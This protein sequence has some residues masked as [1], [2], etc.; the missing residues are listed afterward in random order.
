[1]AFKINEVSE[2]HALGN[3]GLYYDD[4]CAISFENGGAIVFPAY[5]QDADCVRV[6]DDE[7]R[8]LG[9][10]VRDEFEQ[11]FPSTMNGFLGSAVAV[12]RYPK[13]SLER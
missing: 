8:E 1:M 10:W 5:P 9:Y 13:N 3:E 4:E 6:V 12:Q 7:G 11:D 2:A